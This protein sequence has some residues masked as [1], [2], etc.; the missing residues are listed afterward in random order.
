MRKRI[1]LATCLAIVLGVTIGAFAQDPQTPPAS[2]STAAKPITVTGCVQRA[3]APTGTTG[4]TGAA[5]SAETKFVLT[6]AA[7]NTTGTAGTAGTTNP[8]S[9]AV[10]SEYRLDVEDAKVTP[11]VGHKVEITG[12]P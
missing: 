3:Q 10:A 11:H 5:P 9:T 12:T 8:P 6:N 2:Q 1:W 7:I 4:T